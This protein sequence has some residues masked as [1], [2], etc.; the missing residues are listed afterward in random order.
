MTDHYD[1]KTFIVGSFMLLFLF[2]PRPLFPQTSPITGIDV[3]PENI[4][5]QSGVKSITLQS[6]ALLI[7]D[8]FKKK[9][10]YLNQWVFSLGK[11]SAALFE[12][13]LK[14]I[15]E[16]IEVIPEKSKKKYQILIQPHIDDFHFEI[17]QST[18]GIYT[19]RIVYKV[20]IY[21]VAGRMIFSLSMSGKGKSRSK[22]KIKPKVNLWLVK[23]AE[24]AISEAMIKIAS[25]LYSFFANSPLGANQAIELFHKARWSYYKKADY[26]NTITTIQKAIELLE[27]AKPNPFRD[28]FLAESY[29][30]S[31]AA[32][33]CQKSQSQAEEHFQKAIILIPDIKPDPIIYPKKIRDT[34]KKIKSGK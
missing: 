28:H 3:D 22:I 18:I 1:L 5:A 13:V 11:D 24:G 30:L 16:N 17:P 33:V 4:I 21:D 20:Q 29:I 8:D 12:E 15:F 6:A 14:G 23:A 9:Q 19:A 34:F 26:K 32:H 27:Q 25:E 7:T 31:G 10:Y 2:M